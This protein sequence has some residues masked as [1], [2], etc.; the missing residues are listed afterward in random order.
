MA[1]HLAEAILELAAPPHQPC[2]IRMQARPAMRLVPPS[3]V[4]RGW[5]HGCRNQPSTALLALQARVD[6]VPTQLLL[7]HV[8][9]RSLAAGLEIAVYSGITEDEEG[10][11]ARVG[12]Q[13]TLY[14]VPRTAAGLDAFV[15]D[16]LAASP[17]EWDDDGPNRMTLTTRASVYDESW[18][19]VDLDLLPPGKVQAG[20]LQGGNGDQSW[21]TVRMPMFFDSNAPATARVVNDAALYARSQVQ[22][23]RQLEEQQRKAAAA[24]AAEAASTPAAAQQPDSQAVFEQKWRPMRDRAMA[25]LQATLRAVLGLALRYRGPIELPLAAPPAAPA[26]AGA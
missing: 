4:H 21:V 10:T 11:T 7:L 22:L 12:R 24:A 9:P 8:R 13:G 19:S 25:E 17:E 1:H 5:E 18:D 2:F 16:L 6:Y 20:P 15:A 3:R 23:K 26:A 14:A